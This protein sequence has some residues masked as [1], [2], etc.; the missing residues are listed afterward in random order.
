M[1]QANFVWGSPSKYYRFGNNIWFDVIPNLVWEIDLDYSKILPAF[2]ADS[3]NSEL[4]DEFDTA[5]TKYAAF[6]A[7]SAI[8]G[9]QATASSKIQEYQ[10]EIDTQ[11]ATYLYDDQND[12]NFRLQTRRY[13]TGD[14]VLDN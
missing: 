12:M 8:D 10:V 3:D 7:W 2:T 9:K 1:Q 14:Q 6:L 13:S 11:I 4:N 5:I